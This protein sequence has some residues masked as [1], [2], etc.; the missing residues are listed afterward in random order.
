MASALL[1]RE[2]ANLIAEAREFT[3]EEVLPVA[4]PLDSA[5]KDIP[6]ELMDK[7]AERGYFGIIIPRDHGGMGHGVFEYCIISEEISRVWMSAASV[8]A[9]AQGMGTAVRD[10]EWREELMRRAAAGRWIAGAALSEANAGSD[11][12]GVAT[13]AVRDGDDYVV[14]GEKKWCGMAK[15]ADFIMLLARTGEE[16]I[17]GLD[18][19]ILP[20]PRHT[21]PDGVTGEVLPK[22]GYHG[23]T[24]W[25]LTLTDVRV[26]AANILM[27]GDQTG[28]GFYDM[29]RML[30]R[31]RIHT[32]ARSVGA[33]QGAL[34]EATEYAKGRRQFGKAISEF[35]AIQFKLADMATEIEAARQLYYY[36]A[37]LLDAGERCEKE[38]SMA[39]LFASEMSERV[40]SEAL[41]I[42][43]GNGYTTRYSVERHWRDARLTKIF[44]GTS[45]IQKVIISRR[46]LAEAAA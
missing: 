8:L 34:D 21:L 22:I 17:K 11:L 38:C 23:I 36:A 10:A 12:A 26:P 43:G 29:V 31:A 40:T 42:L 25:E 2:R 24:S 15:V 37:E 7:L 46:H 33:A 4:G 28:T 27:Q 35:Q 9:R 1:S 5:Q 13:S 45:E 20:K 19:F 18:T 32:A 44:E 14:N 3:R 39:K 30:N 41:Q 16:R 6:D